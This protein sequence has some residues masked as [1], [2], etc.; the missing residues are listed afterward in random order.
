MFCFH[1]F[2]VHIGCGVWLRED[3]WKRVQAHTKDSLFVKELAVAIWGTAILKTRSLTGKECP[4][5]KGDARPVVFVNLYRRGLFCV[6]LSVF[7]IHVVLFSFL[8]YIDSGAPLCFRT[9]IL[10]GT[11]A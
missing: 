2:Q 11:S 4:T 5:T 7:V 3:V 8:M 6:V 9:Q 10:H 1:L